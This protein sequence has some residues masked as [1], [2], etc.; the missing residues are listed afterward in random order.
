[1][2]AWV[3]SNLPE[4]KVIL[5]WAD[6]MQG[7]CG[8]VYQAS[9][10]IYTGKVAGEMYIK[11]GIKIHVRQMKSLLIPKGVKDERIT[12]RPTLEEMKRLNIRHYK[13][14]QYQYIYFLCDK[15]E[16][17]R[18]LSECLADLNLERPKDNDLSWKVKDIESG[19][20]IPCGK[21]PYKTDFNKEN[22][23]DVFDSMEQMTIFDFIEE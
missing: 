1:M 2:F 19:Q 9:N 15:R 23:D 12:V 4:I 14:N 8:Y 5:T 20:W 22:K 3:K 13:G 18:L 16:K 7:K 11:D 6:G 21:P 10:F 17:K